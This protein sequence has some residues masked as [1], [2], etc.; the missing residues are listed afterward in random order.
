MDNTPHPKLKFGTINMGGLKDKTKRLSTFTWIKSLNHDFDFIQETH[1]HRLRDERYWKREWGGF[2]LWS[3]GT[4]RSRGVGIVFN[5]ER[6]FWVENTIID[7]DGR[8]I[9][10]DLHVDNNVYRLINIYAPN[11]PLARV[12]FLNRL[13]NFITDDYETL[14][15]G[16]FNCVLDYYRDRRNC[17]GKGDIGNIDIKRLMSIH[18][19]EEI[20]RRRHP[21]EAHYSWN[22]GDRHSRIDYWLISSSL[23]AQVEKV[24]YIPCPLSDHSM[25]YI[26]MKTSEVKVGPGIWKMNCEVLESELFNNIFADKWNQWIA[27]IPEYQ[28]LN[29]WWDLVKQRVK[30][31]AIWCSKKIRQDEK[32]QVR[33]L[34]NKLAQLQNNPDRNE[35]EYIEVRDEIKQFYEQKSKGAEVRSR[36]KWHYEGEKPTRYFH[37]MEKSKGK[38]KMWDKIEDSSGNIVTETR[39]ILRVQREYYQNLFTSEPVDID[40]QNKFC[41]KLENKL[42]REQSNMLE[43][44]L[45][46]SEVRKAIQLMKNN[47]SPGPDGIPIEFYKKFWEQIKDILLKVYRHSFEI[48]ELSYSQYLAIIILLYKEGAREILKNWRPISL[49]NVDAKIL[50]KV[51]ANRLKL[52]LPFLINTDQK[53][54]I[55]GRLIGHNIR[56][57]E[58]LIEESDENTILLLQDNEKAFDRVEWSW[59]FKVL[60]AFGFGPN[61]CKWIFTMYNGMKSAVCCNGYT[62]Q[63]FS[64]TRG[65]RQGDSLSAL[66]YV[67]QA[68]P[69]AQY[70][71]TSNVK[72]IIAKD[73]ISN[74]EKEIK[75]CQYVDDGCSTLNNLAQLGPT[76]DI[77]D[78]FG[79]ASGSAL[80]KKK[81]KGLTKGTLTIE[82]GTSTVSLKSVKVRGTSV[83][84]SPG[85]SLGIPIG[86]NRNL[87]EFWQTKV[88]RIEKKLNNWRSHN[89]SLFG[90]V[91]VV[92]SL[93]LSQI[94]Y[95]VEMI[96]IDESVVKEISKLIW[97]FLWE[98]KVVRFPVEVCQIPRNSGGLNLPSIDIV[99][100]VR[101][102]KMLVNIISS[103][104]SWS[105][106][107]RNFITSF[108]N[109]YG[110][111]MPY[112]TLCVTDSTVDIKKSNIP[113]FYK[114]CLLAFQELSRKSRH[115]SLWDGFLWNNDR[116]RHNGKP[117]N[118]KHWARSKINWLKDLNE[119]PDVLKSKL[120]HKAG[121]IFEYRRVGIATRALKDSDV[122][123]DS[124]KPDS[125]DEITNYLLSQKYEVP[126][127]GLKSLIDLS[128]KDIYSM[129]LQADCVKIRSIDYW[130]K[131]FPN[132]C[133]NFE[134][135][136]NMLSN[137]NMGH[138]KSLDFGWK[139]LHGLVNCE[140]RLQKMGYSDGRCKMCL[141]EENV[142]HIFKCLHVSNVWL[143]INETFSIF[144]DRK[145]EINDFQLLIGF[146][147]G[148]KYCDLLNTVLMIVRFEI[149]KSR[150]NNRYDDNPQYHRNLL[151]NVK[152]SLKNH[153]NILL[154]KYKKCDKI[155]K[156]I[157]LI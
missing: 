95:S 61:F 100:K 128:A 141:T 52:V 73:N 34:E 153:L 103:V 38:Q 49:I 56:L 16:D 40:M 7:S 106:F 155:S 30:K 119:H 32:S 59:L 113:H 90:K 124:R 79:K 58:D 130:C 64:V 70:I 43:N 138:R 107:A 57:L 5:I 99:I 105:I 134:N 75:G 114:E 143:Y 82:I 41:S 9:I 91:Y 154:V 139:I 31:I 25:I 110:T 63:Y 108:D 115:D 53:G 29:I 46:F 146:I 133:I 3:R 129:L 71:R 157:D 149:W 66:L 104:E 51:L 78:E 45:E 12:C 96:C 136:Y 67:I 121:F 20:W 50:S 19:L 8:Y 37:N 144:L 118:L 22:R 116:I 131:K 11:N 88:G 87:K 47:R 152:L 89:L 140:T 62:S 13:S 39:D 6:D 35:D 147:N 44:E 92:K 60:E 28:N 55:Q 69:L 86:Q 76:I 81:T 1:C 48:G 84:D 126:N 123:D 150:C 23:D 18:N 4:N 77:I 72:G 15:G 151:S 36:F 85:K 83:S 21:E 68:E 142:L 33:Q 120:T 74:K 94:L 101:R 156:L 54:C 26:V 109:M 132:V 17:I 10:C 117:L 122:L 14:I 97:N 98:D 127:F 137:V 135:W 65:I 111:C 24:E 112:I 102:I 42:T 148:E 27:E 125:Y 2:S 145:F 80:N 93:A